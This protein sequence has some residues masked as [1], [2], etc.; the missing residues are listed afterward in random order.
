MRIRRFHFESSPLALLM[1]FWC[2]FSTHVVVLVVAPL[3]VAFLLT[4]LGMPLR[5]GGEGGLGGAGGETVEISVL[6]S[7]PS[8]ASAGGASPAPTPPDEP[9]VTPAETEAKPEAPTDDTAE[10]VESAEV[11]NAEEEGAEEGGSAE[12]AVESVPVRLSEREREIRRERRRRRRER[13]RQQAERRAAAEAAEAEE[14]CPDCEP[15]AAASESPDANQEVEVA[16]A[17]SSIA[18]VGMDGTDH[19][20]SGRAQGADTAALILGSVGMGA[21]VGDNQLMMDALQ[22]DDAIEGTWVAHHYYPAG[23]DW[24]R[25]TLRINRDGE[26]LSGTITSR[27]WYG[28]AS[29]RR[30]PPCRP[31]GQDVTVQ[32]TGRG[33]IRGERVD[34]AGENYRI[35]R[36]ACSPG[37]FFYNN[38]HFSGRLDTL[39]DEIR[40]RNNDGGRDI[41]TPYRF[42]RVSCDSSD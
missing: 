22:C 28:S 17:P 34:F 24:A 5:A 42:R 25:M 16:E 4:L 29:D 15:N 19:E 8:P 35:T 23:R 9:G 30:P 12:P 38:D 33:W 36:V 40:A 41:N 13:R 2:A 7:D 1:A 18:S 37:A 14:P 6:A 39:R 11:E 20:S 3:I 32:M 21:G 26:R 27:T 31:G 10:A